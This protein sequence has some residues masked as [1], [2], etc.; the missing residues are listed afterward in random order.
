MHITQACIFW[1]TPLYKLEAHNTCIWY[2]LLKH[3]M[4]KLQVSDEKAITAKAT[5]Y[6]Q[7]LNTYFW[8]FIMKHCSILLCI[9][10]D[11]KW[12]KNWVW[13]VSKV[14]HYY[15]VR[16]IES[17]D[18]VKVINWRFSLTE[19]IMK[20]FITIYLYI[21]SDREWIINSSYTWNFHWLSVTFISI[22]VSVL[23][24]VSISVLGIQF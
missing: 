23:I 9:G 17:F 6:L 14:Q 13:L 1:V 20:K 15:F 4:W 5:L 21:I 8:N 10:H 2:F 11:L 18:F 22:S 19:F 16:H 24:S 3:R 7:T 12:C